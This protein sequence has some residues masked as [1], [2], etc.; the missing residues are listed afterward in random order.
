MAPGREGGQRVSEL[1]VIYQQLGRMACLE[2]QRGQDPGL[3]E[4]PD[5]GAALLPTGAGDRHRAK[6]REDEGHDRPRA[7]GRACRK[8]CMWDVKGEQLRVKPERGELQECQSRRGCRH[9]GSEPRF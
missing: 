2:G 9:M 7:A 4:Q 8:C 6:V 1:N 3:G 5:H